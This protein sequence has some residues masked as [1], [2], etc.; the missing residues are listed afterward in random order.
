MCCAASAPTW[1]N[2]NR[3]LKEILDKQ[4]SRQ[5]NVSTARR[6]DSRV[7]AGAQV[8]ATARVGL[9]NSLLGFALEVAMVSAFVFWGF[10]QDAP[11]NMLL[12]IGIPA[13]TVVLWGVFLA[14]RSERRLGAAAVRWVS[15]GAFLAGSGALFAAG[16]PVLGALMATFAV[17]NLAVSRYLAR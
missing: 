16:V 2:R 14:P 17:A 9:V 4:T 10:K 12:G 6:A 3:G 11:W 1:T 15:L 7:R 13:V 5:P 8:R